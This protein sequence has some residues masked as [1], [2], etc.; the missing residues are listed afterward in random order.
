MSAWLEVFLH[1][2][3]GNFLLWADD[4]EVG[5]REEKR[6]SCLGP[7]PLPDSDSFGG[8]KMLERERNDF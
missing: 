1:T 5:A 2:K 6:G 7:A 8:P 3:K 4:K